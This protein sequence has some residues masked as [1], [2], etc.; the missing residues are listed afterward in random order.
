MIFFLISQQNLLKAIKPENR[1]ILPTMVWLQLI[2]V[3]N[4][5]WQFFVVERIADSIRNEMI[6]RNSNSISSTANSAYMAHAVSR[7]TSDLGYS[8]CFLG[9]VGLV[10]F[11]LVA[12]LIFAGVAA[13]VCWIIYWVE[14]SD[15]K[16]KF[17]NNAL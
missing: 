1:R 8:F 9:V 4:L 11:F 16:N 6:D 7:P 10:G 12:I 5:G 14:I 13:M 15:Y 17:L 2:P 3:F